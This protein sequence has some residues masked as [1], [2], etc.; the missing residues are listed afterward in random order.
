MKLKQLKALAM[1][2][3]MLVCA[4]CGK[5]FLS[6]IRVRLCQKCAGRDEN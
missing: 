1:R 4:R 5:P 2:L 6:A 3:E